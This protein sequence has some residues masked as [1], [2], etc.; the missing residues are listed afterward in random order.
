MAGRS[1][2][3]WLMLAALLSSSPG[4]VSARDTAAAPAKARSKARVQARARPQ[5]P[6]VTSILSATHPQL[7]QASFAAGSLLRILGSGFGEGTD[8]HAALK[9]AGIEEGVALRIVSWKDQ[10]IIVELPSVAQL[11]YDAA[12]VAELAKEVHAGKPIVS[13][14]SSIDVLRGG[15]PLVEPISLR[16]ALAAFD[17]DGDGV[18]PP[19]DTNDLDPKVH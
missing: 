15:A 18:S 2:G 11:G 5:P 1:F 17:F 9:T 3:S 19:Q 6:Q 7:T 13:M 8:T 4:L 10:E 12:T 16:I 14:A